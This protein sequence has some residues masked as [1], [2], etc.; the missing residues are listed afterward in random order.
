[1]IGAFDSTAAVLL[2]CAFLA[3]SFGVPATT[4]GFFVLIAASIPFLI[5]AVVNV[6]KLFVSNVEKAN[7]LVEAENY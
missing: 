7:P 1:M 6:G 2:L 3:S 4:I 5:D